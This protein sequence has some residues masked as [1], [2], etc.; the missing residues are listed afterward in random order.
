[1]TAG[2]LELGELMV[3]G[4]QRRLTTTSHN[5]A[6]LTTPG[7]RTGIAFEQALA[8]GAT[9]FAITT[10]FT[11][12]ALRATG[13]PLDLAIASNGFF[14]VRGDEGVYYTRGGRFTRDAD[15][16]VVDGRGLALQTADGQDLVLAGA[17]V[18]I[19]DDGTVL[20]N[21]V[22]IARVGV[23]EDA[24]DVGPERLGGA[25]FAAPDGAMRDVAS[26]SVRQ[27]MIEGSNVDL[28]T[29]MVSVMAA[30]RQAEIG[31]RVVQAYDSLI[32]QTISTLG[33][34]QA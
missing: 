21:D 17:R 3:V 10:D 22:P 26:P 25:Y 8:S 19:T 12:G 9:N 29:E 18:E 15:G 33:R 2:L 23:F 27:G 7:Y 6:N 14:C 16:R 1:M 34:V 5:V 24:A 20:E 4:A 31:A 32:G 30:M 13:Q 28:S 11:G